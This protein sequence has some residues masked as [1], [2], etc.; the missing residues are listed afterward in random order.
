MELHAKYHTWLS[1]DPC[2]M[3][4]GKKISTENNPRQLGLIFTNHST[5]F[6]VISVMLELTITMQNTSLSNTGVAPVLPTSIRSFHS[7]T[8]I[9]F[10]KGKWE[11]L[12]YKA[13]SFKF[14][15]PWELHDAHAWFTIMHGII[16]W[17]YVHEK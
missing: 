15:S 4:R 1:M 8:W 9:T 7:T 17:F 12:S 14:G 13:Y 10:L 2:F 3:M 11:L 5:W 6:C 16:A